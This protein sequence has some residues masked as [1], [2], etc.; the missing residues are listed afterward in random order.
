MSANLFFQEHLLAERSQEIEREI[1]QSHLVNHLTQQRRNLGRRMVGNVGRS[2]VSLGTFLEQ[3]DS[4]DEH[5]SF[6]SADDAIPSLS[7]SGKLL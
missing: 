3:V 7:G 1:T 6:S 2:L 4:C 5:L